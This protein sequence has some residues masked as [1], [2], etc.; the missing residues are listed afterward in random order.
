MNAILSYA[1]S[2]SIETD[3]KKNKSTDFNDFDI[4]TPQKL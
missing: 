4:L 2:E 3:T 1:S